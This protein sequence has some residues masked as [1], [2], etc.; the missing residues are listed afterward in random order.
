MS[1]RNYSHTIADQINEFLVDDDWNFSF[2]EQK[3]VF[4]FTVTLHSKLRQLRYIIKV[5]SDHYTVYAYSPIGAESKDKQMMAEMAEYIC[6]ANYNTKN[7]NFELDMSDGEIRYKVYVDCEDIDL[8]R[9]VIRNSI[10]T[11]TMMF[12]F[13]GNGLVDVI[14]IGASAKYSI[15]KSEKSLL[16]RLEND[17]DDE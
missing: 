10:I 4:T 1:E 3:G 9:S 7:G 13:Y 16:S 17:D 11:P 6:R 8:S 5:G 15:K 14:F 2:D 12:E